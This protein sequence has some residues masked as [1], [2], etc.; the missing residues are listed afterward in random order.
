MP[1]SQFITPRN[2]TLFFFCQPVACHANHTHERK[3]SYSFFST[4]LRNVTQSHRAVGIGKLGTG[5]MG[6]PLDC[7][8]TAVSR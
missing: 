3:L 8:V 6:M 5:G 7:K 1:R 4:D 2:E